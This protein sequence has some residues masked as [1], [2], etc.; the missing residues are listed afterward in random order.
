M[1]AGGPSHVGEKPV[2]RSISVLTGAVQEMSSDGWEAEAS[3]DGSRILFV[4]GELQNV[5]V[6][7]S[8]W[9]SPRT[10]FRPP[11]GDVAGSVHWVPGGRRIGY[12]TGKNGAPDA[13]I[14]TRNLEG[15]DPRPVVRADTESVVFAPDGRVF[16]TTKDRP[17]QYGASLW[18]TAIDLGTGAAI[19]QPTRL[20]TWPGAAAAQ[21]LT[22]SA[23]GRRLAVT[24]Q[25][26]QSDIY[27]L[28]LDASGNAVTASRQLTTDTQVDWPS[29]WTRDGSAMLFYS[30]RHGALHAFRQ[31]IDAETPQPVA[32]GGAHVR[33][34][35]VSADGKW[36]V[37]VEMAYA[38][39]AARVVRAPKDGGAA[40]QV[41][42]IRSDLESATMDFFGVSLGT[43][44]IGAHAFPDLRCP[45]HVADGSCLL[46]EAVPTGPAANR[47]FVLT[48]LNPDTGQTQELATLPTDGAGVSFWDASPDGSRV[49][50]G[51]FSWEGGDRVTLLDLATGTRT[52]V[53]PKNVKNLCDV[54]WAADG[55][56][57]FAAVCTIRDSEVLHIGLDGTA[58]VL[59]SYPSR[60]VMNPRPSP[61]GRSLLIGLTETSSN[62][63]TIER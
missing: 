35:Q 31:P 21:P 17:P 57:L 28:Q 47:R 13:E 46:L 8:Q 2:I 56:S 33:A 60:V 43:R 58:H 45:A 48:R 42:S 36:I 7:G 44:G 53:Q 54:A 18:T 1:F 51:Q 26:V 6:A 30:N 59:R 55:R 29:Q 39:D 14:Q 10:L 61:D 62:V 20:A 50:F 40:Q 27:Q 41:V 52:T 12:L 16:Y 3:A 63:W 38:P 22:V 5:Q 32:T 11:P 34:P 24:K 23:D 37:Y 15:G 9:E 25:F 4:D 19:G 49:A